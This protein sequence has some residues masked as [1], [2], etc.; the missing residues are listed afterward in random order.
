MEEA[1][2]LSVAQI[3]SLLTV[4]VGFVAIFLLVRAAQ[5]LFTGQFKTTLWLGALSFVLTLTGVTAMMFYHFGGESEVAEFLEHVWYAFIFLSLL[6]SLFESYHLINF[7]KGFVKIKEFT[8]KKTAKNK[9]IKR[10]R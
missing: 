4:L 1:F 10:K 8:K 9:S 6:F 5:G 2:I 7:G 3:S